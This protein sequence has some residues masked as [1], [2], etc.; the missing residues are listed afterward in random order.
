MQ[1]AL[2][3]FALS[4]FLVY[5]YTLNTRVGVYVCVFISILCCCYLA[6]A[7]NICFDFALQKSIKNMCATI[8]VY[9]L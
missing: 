4:H 7:H 2:K 1:S 5:T 8:F 3:Y 9:C 6:L